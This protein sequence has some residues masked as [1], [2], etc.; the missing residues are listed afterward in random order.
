M[1]HVHYVIC[2][3]RDTRG[4]DVTPGQAFLVAKVASI[5]PVTDDG[6]R[7]RYFIK[8]SDYAIVAIDNFWSHRRIGPRYADL[9]KAKE[10]GLDVR[11]LTFQPMP[12]TVTDRDTF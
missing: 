6:A 2:A 11:A 3:G 1:R 7:S 5:Q 12:P 10:M 9:S 4:A 8:F